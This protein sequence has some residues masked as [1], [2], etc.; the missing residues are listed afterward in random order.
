MV[1]SQGMTGP[2]VR[3]LQT[4]LNA[5]LNPSPNLRISGLFDAAT[6]QAVRSFQAANWLE[7]DGVAGPATLDALNGDEEGA[8]IRHNLPYIARPDVTLGW[9]AAV[10]MLRR[11][12]VGVVRQM[13]PGRF[14]NAQGD[15]LSEGSGQR[16]ELHRAFAN[17]H[18]LRYRP[19]KNW[20]AS[21]LVGM[22]RTGPVAIE[23]LRRPTIQIRGASSVLLVIAG[24]RG[25][26]RG[27]GAST[28]LRIHDPDHD[29]TPG[30]YSCTFTSLGSRLPPAGYAIFST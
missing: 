10:A 30:V 17:Q 27:D 15:L 5:R 7:I 3:E 29:S 21:T 16:V 19:P 1:L 20:P 25:A 6:V 13:T 11:T 23:Y 22:L 4:V 9:A 12:S 8:A 26:H 28:T 14:L 24:V 18:A 2:P